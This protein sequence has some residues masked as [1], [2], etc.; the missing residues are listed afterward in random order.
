MTNAGWQC[1]CL[2]AA[3]C[4]LAIY[5]P[6]HQPDTHT[7][8]H[9]HTHVLVIFFKYI[10][11]LMLMVSFGSVQLTSAGSEPLTLASITANLLP[12]SC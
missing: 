6:V 4:C 9:A 10:C 12:T 3:Q 8:T 7:D 5:I 2:P 11:H 1:H